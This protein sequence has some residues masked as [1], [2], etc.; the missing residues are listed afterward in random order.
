LDDE[1]HDWIGEEEVIKLLR[2]RAG[3]LAHYPERELISRRY[4][5]H[6]R[7]LTDAALA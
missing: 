5:N 3:W 7:A 4:L 2:H 6:Q 1:K